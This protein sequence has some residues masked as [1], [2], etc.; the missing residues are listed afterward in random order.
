MSNW[1]P[2]IPG[3]MLG[4]GCILILFINRQ[5]EMPLAAPLVTLPDTVAGYAG[6]DE[7]IGEDEQRVAGMDAYLFRIF[8][9]DSGVAFTLYVGYYDHQTQG[10][11]IHSPKNCLPGAGWEELNNQVAV[12]PLEDGEVEVN[13]YLLQN[14]D[15][16]VVVFYWYQGRGRVES[17]EYKV[18]YELLRDAAIRGRTEEALV[19][20]VVPL[21]YGRTN[22]EAEAMASDVI[23]E[24]IPAMREVLPEW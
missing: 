21:I 24:M 10:K 14:G 22:A 5:Q 9:A 19:R 7:V 2:W 18:K 16:Q 1:R 12:I 3:S 11:T 23:R 13:R 8:P 15:D 17:N 20:I 6:F 4:I